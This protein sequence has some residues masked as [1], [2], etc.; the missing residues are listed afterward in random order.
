[1]DSGAGVRLADREDGGNLGV[2]E[3]GEELE[4]DQ[5][6]LTRLEAREGGAQGESPLGA[7]AVTP[8]AAG[9]SWS[10]PAT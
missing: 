7:L 3:A 1:V 6:A 9:P 10:R 8:S 2:A 4:R 5:L